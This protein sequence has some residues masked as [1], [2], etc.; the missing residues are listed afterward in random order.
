MSERRVSPVVYFAAG[1]ALWQLV[2]W[3]VLV[4]L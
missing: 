1:F 4:R 3:L 2:F